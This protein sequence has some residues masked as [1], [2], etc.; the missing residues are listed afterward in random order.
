MENCFKNTGFCWKIYKRYRKSFLFV[1]AMTV[2][3]VLQTATAFAANPGKVTLNKT[4]IKV[5]VGKT[6]QL[7]PTVSPNN[8][9]VNKKVTWISSDEKVAAVDENGK[10]KGKKAGTATITVKTVNGKTAVCKVKVAEIPPTKVTLDKE[11]VKIDIGQTAKLQAKIA[12]ADATRKTLSWSS[13]DQS[14]AKVNSKG[15]ITALAEGKT[16][17]TVKTVNGKKRSCVVKV[18][19]PKKR[20]YSEYSYNNG[21]LT[22]TTAGVTKTYKAYTSNINGYLRSSGC[23]HA[24]VCLAASAFG[25][26]HN[27]YELYTA[28]AGTK[29][30]EKYAIKKLG[31]SPTYNGRLAISL[32]TAQQILKDDGIPVK[33]RYTFQTSKA[34]KEITQHLQKGLPVIVKCHNQT[35]YG[36]KMA[37]GHHAMALL[38]IDKK[39]YVI[40]YDPTNGRINFSHANGKAFKLTVKQFIERHAKT[41]YGNYKTPYVLTL[42]SAG[43]YILVG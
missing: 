27:A 31:M 38:G 4:S 35:V 30:G 14:V 40:C 42:E 41:S 8:S 43:G 5:Y 15:K 17:I 20:K 39:G 2:L 21:V 32:M 12:P 3:F 11:I 28:S 9:T 24:A 16:T 37:N 34:V 7:K 19:D 10:V 18:S 13:S 6:Y 23:V 1:L 29:W 33:V 36:N 26:K 25:V 22:V